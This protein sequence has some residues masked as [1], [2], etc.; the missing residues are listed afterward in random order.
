VLNRALMSLVIRLLDRIWA[1]TPAHVRWR[2]WEAVVRGTCVF[3]ARAVRPAARFA[4]N[5]LFAVRGVRRYSLRRSG[6]TLFV[7]HPVMDPGMVNEVMNLGVYQP[8][9]AVE[10]ALSRVEAPHIVDVGAH[11]GATTLFLLERFPTARVLAV[12]PNPETAALLRR[13]IAVNGLEGQCEVVEAAAGVSAGSALMEGYS[14]FAHL[15]RA[16]TEETVDVL[17]PMRKYQANGAGP[18]DVEVVDVLPLFSGA[19]LVKMDIEGAEWA[20]LEDP[21]FGSLGISALVL[22]YH[23]QGAPQTDTTAAVRA[24]LREAGFTVGEPFQQYGP[25]GM[26]WAWRG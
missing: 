1:R 14:A 6:R 8:P 3:A 15:V 7:R 13:M 4:V 24:L 17:P 12:E 23:P 19:D 18:V 21:R 20:I 26:I 5:E 2:I 9:P 22:E 25:V 11:I 16:D 10:L